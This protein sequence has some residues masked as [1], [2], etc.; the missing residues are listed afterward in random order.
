MIL[1]A[2][3]VGGLLLD[4]VFW[5]L[6]HGQVH[7]GGFAI[8]VLTFGLGGLFLL[9]MSR[10]GLA[11]PALL[12]DDYPVAQAMF[13]SDE[14]TERKWLTLAVLLAKSLIGGYVAGMAPFWLASFI[15][16]DSQLPSWFPWALTIVS[17]GGVT[18]VEPT[19]FIGFALLYLES[20]AL[21]PM[22]SGAPNRQPVTQNPD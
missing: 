10:F 7:P 4:W 22:S 17:I 20:S 5:I 6:R 9:V 3:G 19:M 8:S 16:A 2:A 21:L 1:A 12:L 11:I 14:L 13:R 15:P 18:V